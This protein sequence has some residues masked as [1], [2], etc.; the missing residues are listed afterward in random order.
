M[1]HSNAQVRAVKITGFFSVHDVL[2]FFFFF[3]FNNLV[4]YAYERYNF[5]LKFSKNLSILKVF[6]LNVN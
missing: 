1:L 3:F 6:K 5:G 4:S 2:N